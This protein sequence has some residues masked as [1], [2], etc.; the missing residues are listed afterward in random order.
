MRQ[1]GKRRTRSGTFVRSHAT[2]RSA[3]GRPSLIGGGHRSLST[4]LESPLPGASREDS[5]MSTEGGFNQSELASI[6]RERAKALIQI[7]ANVP[8]NENT[9]A[10]TRSGSRSDLVPKSRL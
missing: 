8:E 2:E 1:E 10:R 5:V 6:R 7:L 3:A 9:L 4:G